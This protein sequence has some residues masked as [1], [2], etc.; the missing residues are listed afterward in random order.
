[1]KRVG[2][3]RLK[4]GA[5]VGTHL[6]FLQIFD[7]AGERNVPP[8]GHSHVPQVADKAG[9]RVQADVRAYGIYFLSLLQ[10]C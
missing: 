9:L 4:L 2:D 5:S 3:F 6:M 8:L 10:N 1:M 7:G